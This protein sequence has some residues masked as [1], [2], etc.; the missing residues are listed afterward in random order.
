MRATFERGGTHYH[1]GTP[2]GVVRVLEAAREGRYRIRVHYGDAAT[3]RDWCEEF[4]CEGYVSRT[5]GPRKM[6]MLLAN[7]RSLGG[8]VILTHVVVRVDAFGPRRTLYKH[9][10]YHH[11]EVRLVEV[12]HTLPDGCRLT[13]G[14]LVGGADHANF[15]TPRQRTRWLTKMGLAHAPA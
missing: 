12:D 6:P 2:P 4:G 5:M 14:V 7:E 1:E 11:G 15:Q 10:S 9:P 13:S 8:H 3:G